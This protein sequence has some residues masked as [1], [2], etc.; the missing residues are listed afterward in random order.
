[1]FVIAGVT[2][3]VGSV[4]AS[5]LLAQ[6]KQIMVIVRTSAKGEDWSRRGAE[7]A[8]GDVGDRDFLTGAL[9]GADGF[10]TL[11]PPNVGV[12]DLFAYQRQVADAIAAAVAASKVPHV[13]LLSS[14]GAELESGTG[15]IKG[16]HHAEER[17][18]ATGTVLTALRAGYFQE[19]IESMLG[20]ARGA[21]IF[22]NFGDAGAAVPSV[23]TRDVGEA[24]AA[25]LLSPP[26]R[27]ETVDVIGPAYSPR[28]LAEKVA[29]ALGK[30]VQVVDVPESSWVDALMQA[31]FRRPIAEVFA[32]LQGAIAH[33]LLR[34]RGD[35]SVHGKREIDEV[36]A[37]LV[38]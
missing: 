11:L 3:H 15:P 10:F 29:R 1:M 14:I 27:S 7:V 35:R 5:E 21:G 28:Q 22:P 23:A 38:A 37:H 25:A 24:G 34:P 9:R 17:L 36:I 30:P 33:G 8:V 32:E 2:G 26:A 12:E 18:R 20:P 6:G 31:G 13:V 16:L 19:N 4:V